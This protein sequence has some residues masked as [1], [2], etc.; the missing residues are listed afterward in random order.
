MEIYIEYAFLENFLIDAMLLT[1]ALKSAKQEIRVLRIVFSALLGSGFALVFP[2]LKLNAWLSVLLKALVG[3]L[4]CL[5]AHKG[6]KRTLLTLSLFFL[7]SFALG[8]AILGI[9]GFLSVSA[10]R[11]DGYLLTSA[12]I[13]GVLAA[14][15]FFCLW[16]FG[17]ARGIY[18]R[19]AVKR[20]VY[21]CKITLG[22]R[23]VKTEGFL[24]SGNGAKHNGIPVC[25]LSPDLAYE[26]LGEREMTEE[27]TILTVG[28]EKQIKIFL[29]DSLEI[30][31]AGQ[32]NI[33]RKIY[34]SPSNG[35]RAREYKVIF[36]AEVGEFL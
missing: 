29:A 27:M 26:L 19:R 2:L 32:P 15:V 6:K 34:F 25:F 33:I 10:E 21:A 3:I 11:G 12:P 20:F 22:D 7:Y 8:G 28:G 16:V 31:C 4:L 36:N 17:L 5:L 18:R 13:G 24:D 30:Y 35:I 23:S 1:L 9:S 14:C